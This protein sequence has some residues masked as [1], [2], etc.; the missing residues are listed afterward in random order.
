MPALPT[1]H[2]VLVPHFA[3]QTHTAGQ[4]RRRW[5]GGERRR[6][7]KRERKREK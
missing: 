2:S 5:G 6:E 3:Q 1:H 4:S 7:R